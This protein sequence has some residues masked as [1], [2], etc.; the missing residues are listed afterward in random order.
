MNHNTAAIFRRLRC[1]D[2]I[3]SQTS[4]E[5]DVQLLD[6]KE[7]VI[8][9][10]IEEGAF[11]AGCFKDSFKNFNN[12]I[13]FSVKLSSAVIAEIDDKPTYAYF[14]HYRTVNALIDRILLKAGIFLG[15]NGYRYF[16]IGASQTVGGHD[17]YAGLYSHKRGAVLAG[18]GTVGKNGLFQSER[19][20]TG[21]RLGTLFTDLDLHAVNDPKPSKCGAC[22]RCVQ[23]CP[24]MC[25]SGEAF[26]IA[27]PEKSLVDRKSCSDYMKKAFQKI[28]RG[29][30]CGICMSVCPYTQK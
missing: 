2:I 30:V 8:S 1:C 29:S 12:G 25:L 26:D 23:A 19:W 10:M 18:L 20:G 13:S 7:K 16:P 11:E 28:G 14:H 15:K 9:I 27:Q 22:R 6:L 24:A 17:T 5:M 4:L 3:T 21:V